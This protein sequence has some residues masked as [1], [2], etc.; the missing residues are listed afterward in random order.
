[1][2]W[3]ETTRLQYRR[4]GLRYSS[5][6][7]DAEWEL[8]AP[9]VAEDRRLGRPRA[10]VLRAVVEA[11]F[12]IAATGC[13][14]RMLPK[15]FPPYSTVQRYFYRWRDT[16]AWERINHTLLMQAREAAG[17][18]AS[19]S[20]GVIDSQSV[21]TTEAGGPR[22][23]DAGKKIKG[24][25]RHIITD[26]GGRLVGAIVH[27]AEVQDRDGA[28]PLLASIRSS[29]P[30]LRHVFADAG[31]AGAKLETAL[32]KLGRWTVEIVRRPQGTE[33][34]TLLPRRWVVERTIAWLNRNRRLAKDF[35]ASIESALAW[36][37]IASVKLLTRRIVMR[38]C[39]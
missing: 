5:D 10:T 8:I 23:F 7:L 4:N 13:Q 2:S 19:P 17:R 37:M 15:E 6:M 1:M 22:G 27:G 12:Y 30:W 29:F 25:K 32:A 11:I 33:C 9:F 31:Y 21:K 36:L 3:T 39:P 34:F 38:I 18:E 16:G 26:T 35:E 28:V 14:W 20:A 24:R